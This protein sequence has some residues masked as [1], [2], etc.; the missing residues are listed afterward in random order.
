MEMVKDESLPFFFFE[1]ITFGLQHV[2]RKHMSASHH[3]V[4]KSV[5]TCYA[6]KPTICTVMQFEQAVWG[7]CPQVIGGRNTQRLLNQRSSPV[8]KNAW[9]KMMQLWWKNKHNLYQQPQKQTHPDAIDFFRGRFFTQNPCV[10]FAF[11]ALRSQIHLTASVSFVKMATFRW[12]RLGNPMV[13]WD[14]R[15]QLP[16]GTPSS[17]IWNVFPNWTFK[18]GECLPS[19]T[20]QPLELSDPNKL[21]KNPAEFRPCMVCC[22]KKTHWDTTSLPWKRKWHPPINKN[23]H[24]EWCWKMFFSVETFGTTKTKGRNLDCNSGGIFFTQNLTVILLE[25]LLSKKNCQMNLES[26]HQ[27]TRVWMEVSNYSE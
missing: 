11:L 20:L 7:L 22:A 9:K 23:Q 19:S 13:P 1:R 24:M 3:K 21:G 16:N 25:F 15:S 18:L 27:F 6:K 4:R 12:G 10:F 5:C 8:Q 17:V 26:C 2:S 14:F